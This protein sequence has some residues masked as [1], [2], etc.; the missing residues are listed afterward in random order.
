MGYFG[1]SATTHADGALIVKLEGMLDIFA[2]QDFKRYFRGLGENSH[3]RLV[4]VDL[5][6]VEYIA[7][8]GWSVLLGGRRILNLHGGDLS[9]FGLHQGLRRVYETMHIAAMLP[10]AE[11]LEEADRLVHE[12]SVTGAQP[13]Q[14]NPGN[15]EIAI[16][17][18]RHGSGGQGP[19]PQAGAEGGPFSGGALQA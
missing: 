9:I 8:S 11:T 13:G 18:D 12:H 16:S 4:V 5:G 3:G 17:G 19:E 6:A 10:M 15:G 2:F 14:G 7:S 1:I